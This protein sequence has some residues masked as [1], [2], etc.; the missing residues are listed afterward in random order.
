MNVSQSDSNHGLSLKKSGPTNELQTGVLSDRVMKLP[1][2]GKSQRAREK[3]RV[4]DMHINDDKHLL[5]LSQPGMDMDI[6]EIMMLHRD[7]S[8]PLSNNTTMSLEDT[9]SVLLRHTLSDSNLDDNGAVNAAIQQW[10][11]GQAPV[12]SQ[13]PVELIESLDWRI[14]R[15]KVLVPAI[16]AN[17]GSENRQQS[18]SGLHSEQLH[19]FYH[20]VNEMAAIGEWLRQHQFRLLAVVFPA[21]HRSLPQLKAVIHMA[22]VSE[23]MYGLVQGVTEQFSVGLCEMANE[24]EELIY[25]KRS[26]YGDTLCQEGLSWKAMGI[27]VDTALLM[28]VR[29]HLATITEHCLTRVA[30][31]YERRA[32]SASAYG[33][34][35][36]STDQLLLL[37]HQVMH[38]AT[39][40]AS[41]CGNGFVEYAPQVMYIVA[42]SSSWAASKFLGSSAATS[43]ADSAHVRGKQLE[44]RA[45]RQ[46]RTSESLLKLLAYSRAILTTDALPLDTATAVSCQTLASSLVDLSWSLAQ[47]LAAIRAEGKMTNPSS[48]LLLFADLVFKFARRVV[49]CGGHATA[50]LPFVLSRL[51]KMQNFVQSLAPQKG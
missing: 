42:E 45:L 50:K 37:S 51:H 34:E 26:L 4:N 15:L 25:A 30:R 27:P 2:T 35:E 47:T 6:A 36:I 28:R 18:P 23:D 20:A 32:R 1:V 49:D 10:A 21:L 7:A 19:E 33:K 16:L 11:L 24:Y 46:V 29:Q 22:R 40:C 3:T 8:E 9:F 44:S 12:V 14:A 41:L 17:L 13:T 31:T 39:L 48:V 43:A 5:E 38:A